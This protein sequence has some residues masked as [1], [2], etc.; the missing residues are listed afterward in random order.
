MDLIPDWKLLHAVD[1]A[2]TTQTNKHQQKTKH[3]KFPIPIKME[4]TQSIL[5]LPLNAVY[6]LGRIH[7]TSIGGF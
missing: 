5:F 3:K 7:G 4:K 2:K 6:N 1:V